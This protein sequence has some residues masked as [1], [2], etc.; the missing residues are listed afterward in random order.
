MLK[1]VGAGVGA[2]KGRLFAA[3]CCRCVARRADDPRAIAF[4]DVVE[5]LADRPEPKDHKTNPFEAQQAKAFDALNATSLSS[6]ARA[7]ITA[8]INAGFAL[9]LPS[10]S[11]TVARYARDAVSLDG[12]D[13]RRREARAQARMVREILGNPFRP[14]AFNPRWRTADTLGL[15]RG[16]YEDRAFDR[17]PLLADALMDAGCADEQVLGHCRGEGP[18]VRG[19]WVVDL[20]LGKE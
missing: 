2:R 4:I 7:A 14:I 11:V 18:H 5:E 8:I 13:A 17:M 9:W 12:R 6:P 19:C 20:V 10:L 16:I 1:F 3:A 15:A